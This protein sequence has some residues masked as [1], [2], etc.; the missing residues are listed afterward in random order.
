MSIGAF[1]RR[2]GLTASA[3]RFYADAGLL[4][5]AETDDASGYRFYSE[6]Q[7]ESAVLL[8]RLREIGMPLAGVRSVLAAHPEEGIRLVDEHVDAVVDDAAA[9]RERAVRIRAELREKAA[10]RGRAELRDR[11]E[12]AATP[13]IVVAEASGPVLASAIEQ[14]LTAVSGD[15]EIA[16]LG[17][18]LVEARSGSVEVIATDRY[19]MSVR[20]LAGAAPTGTIWVGTVDGDD[21]RAALTDLRHSPSA[22][23][24]A[25]GDGVWIRPRGAGDRYCRLVDGQF[26]DHRAM[27]DALRPVETRV[28]VA[29]ADLLRALE[30]HAADVVSIDV[31]ETGI[32]VSGNESATGS[33]RLTAVV[34]GTPTTIRF[35]MTTLYP[36]IA[37]AIAADL[38][39]D[40]RGPDQPVTVRS[41]D[42]GDLTTYV[43]PTGDTTDGAVG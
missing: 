2:S 13:L 17:G 16:V 9:V 11:A 32:V 27:L 43:M 37:T 30:A 24:E 23:I 10:L 21:L 8:R 34:S 5:P 18:V 1:A 20:T 39:L 14:V 25:I 29:K 33:D 19:R 4:P 42:N 31:T 36:A 15:P 38:L 41:A 3:L 7:L 12:S 35:A 28:V 40:L 6:D 26:P 22:R